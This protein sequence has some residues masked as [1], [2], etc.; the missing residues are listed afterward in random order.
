MVR[1]NDAA[2][3]EGDEVSYFDLTVTQIPFGWRINPHRMNDG[4]LAAPVIISSHDLEW[5]KSR[6]KE[7][8]GDNPDL[9]ELCS[10]C[11]EDNG[12]DGD[13]IKFTIFAGDKTHPIVETGIPDE[14]LDTLIEALVA[15]RNLRKTYGD[16]QN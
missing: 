8:V 1:A 2:S 6:Q 16:D 4:S 7:F 12:Q 10:L 14:S 9:R 13:G 3:L 5:W 11:L 15:I